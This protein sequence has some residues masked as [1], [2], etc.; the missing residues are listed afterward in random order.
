MDN[1]IIRENYLARIRPFYHSKYIKA[2]TGVR[3][4]G[5][6]ELL[7]QIIAE[8]KALGI[9][10]DHIIV[11][12]LEGKSGEG[13]TTRK[14][15]EKK[16]DKLINDKEKYYIFIDEVQHIRKFEEAVASIRV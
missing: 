10:E 13:L 15:I 6:S 1:I 16:I 11:F 3:R 8:I 14:K 9:S 5:K 4:C 2:I 7:L 12:D